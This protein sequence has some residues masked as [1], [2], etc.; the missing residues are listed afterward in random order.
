M[1]CAFLI[2]VTVY[3]I[4]GDKINLFK[5]FFMFILK[6]FLFTLQRSINKE[7]INILFLL[8]VMSI[9]PSI[10]DMLLFLSRYLINL[11]MIKFIHIIYSYQGHIKIIIFNVLQYDPLWLRHFV[12]I[13]V[14]SISIIQGDQKKS[15]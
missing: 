1:S 12:S 5:V 14:L 13:S 4:G 9:W 7:K 11:I 15:W 3:C 10:I 8:N 6:Q 2:H